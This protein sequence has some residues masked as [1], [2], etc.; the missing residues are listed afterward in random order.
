MTGDVHPAIYVPME[1]AQTGTHHAA[2]K[3]RFVVGTGKPV[4]PHEALPVDYEL[5]KAQ[6]GGSA[7]LWSQRW[8][9]L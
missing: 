9:K 6:V 4:Q 1:R 8:Q 5:R 3:E 7:Y 2:G